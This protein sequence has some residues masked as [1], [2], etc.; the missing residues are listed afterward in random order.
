MHLNIIACGSKRSAPEFFN[1]IALSD[2]YLIPLVHGGLRYSVRWEY[3]S[4]GAYNN[5]N[6]H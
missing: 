2:Q 4:G 3:L 1:G 5:R 6:A